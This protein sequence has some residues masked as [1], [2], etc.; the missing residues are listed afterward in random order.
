MSFFFLVIFIGKFVTNSGFQSQIN[1]PW[2]TEG[3]I[4][5]KGDPKW[6]TKTFSLFPAQKT[7]TTA[8]LHL[9]QQKKLW[10]TCTVS[11]SLDWTPLNPLIAQR[12]LLSRH[13]ND[14]FQ[15]IK[16]YNY[17]ITIHPTVATETVEQ[18]SASCDGFLGMSM[19]CRDPG[20]TCQHLAELPAD[21]G[22]VRVNRLPSF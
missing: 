6:W 7:V 20:I 11:G 9:T 14:W 19:T 3:W 15:M 17:T 2:L 13:Q 22:L 4:W 12:K 16:N 5:S 18:E 21:S 10:S 8:S 1:T